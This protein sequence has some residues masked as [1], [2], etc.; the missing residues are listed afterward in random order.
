MLY[1][2]EQNVDTQMFTVHDN[3]VNFPFPKILHLYEAQ[4]KD[5]IKNVM[6]KNTI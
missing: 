2:T 3:H 5:V 1:Y 6:V 4:E